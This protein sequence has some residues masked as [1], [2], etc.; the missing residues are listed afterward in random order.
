M[1]QAQQPDDLL[2]KL[3]DR[4]IDPDALYFFATAFYD[5]SSAS[6]FA[7]ENPLKNKEPPARGLSVAEARFRQYAISL[8]LVSHSFVSHSFVSYSS[9][10]IQLFFGLVL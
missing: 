7:L 4:N 3:R 10:D 5:V 1:E 6:T 8:R 2:K 9:K